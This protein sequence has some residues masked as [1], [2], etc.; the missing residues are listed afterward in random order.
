MPPIL[1]PQSGVGSMPVLGGRL[2]PAFKSGYIHLAR[3]LNRLTIVPCLL[4]LWSATGADHGQS[5]Q[6]RHVVVAYDVYKRLAHLGQILV[7]YISV[8]PDHTRRRSR[9]TALQLVSAALFPARHV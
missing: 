2:A 7:C 1:G 6:F 9:H 3:F 5:E 4:H 8:A